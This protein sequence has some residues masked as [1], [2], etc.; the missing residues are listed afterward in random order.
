MTHIQPL[1][2]LP[3]PPV[4]LGLRSPHLD[5]VLCT[6]PAVAFFEAHPENYILD[7]SGLSKL[8]R[9][10]M[11]Y[12]LSLHAVGLSLGSRDGVDEVHLSRL[13]G[14]ADRLEPFLMSDH[15]SW[16]SAGG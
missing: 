1:A 16:S 8:A 10:R 12:P 5:E 2:K 14:L 9:V 4:G 13:R 15:L 7:R 3:D 11:D 6:R